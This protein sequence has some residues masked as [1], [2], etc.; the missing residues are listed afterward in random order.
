VPSRRRRA[1]RR[2]ASAPQAIPGIAGD[3]YNMGLGWKWRSFPTFAAFAVGGLIPS[4]I[5]YFAET[6]GL[7]LTLY[8][9][10]LLLASF[11]LMH[12]TFR[13]TRLKRYQAARRQKSAA[14]GTRGSS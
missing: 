6:T 12:Y 14:Q 5:Y 10:F 13:W 11:S 9:A 2:E 4:I 7:A 3:P 1:R 8:L